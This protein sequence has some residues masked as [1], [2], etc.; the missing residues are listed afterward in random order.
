MF[1]SKNIL[2]ILEAIE[3]IFIY[4]NDFANKQLNFNP[5]FPWVRLA[6]RLPVR[7]SIDEVPKGFVLRAGTTCTITLK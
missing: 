4:S 7:I 5:S 1:N 2:T 6:Q 3:K